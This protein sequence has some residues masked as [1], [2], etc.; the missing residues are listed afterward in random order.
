MTT[1]DALL[2]RVKQRARS[3]LVLTVA[4]EG[5]NLDLFDTEILCAIVASGLGE[6]CI[7]VEGSNSIR[8]VADSVDV[9]VENNGTIVFAW[10]GNEPRM[11]RATWGPTLV[12][13]DI[14]EW[15]TKA[16][17]TAAAILHRFDPGDTQG[18]GIFAAI[19]GTDHI[20]WLTRQEVQGRR[21]PVDFLR[22]H[23]ALTTPVHNARGAELRELA[24]A[25]AQELTG[26]LRDAPLA[27]P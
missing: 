6:L 9:E 14:A 3:A 21:S 8:C 2:D 13:E 25:L 16:L 22:I 15:L 19:V 17:A 26:E 27:P 5:F 1:A 7:R 10:R 24:A 12:V 18:I 4:V 23:G 20:V 11:P